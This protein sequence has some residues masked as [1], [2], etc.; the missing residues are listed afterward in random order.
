MKFSILATYYQKVNSPEVVQRFIDSLK[1]QTF[2]DFEVLIAH[3]G[4]EEIPEFDT[5]DLRIRYIQTQH[6]GL[7]GHPQR[8]FMMFF[9]RGDYF[10]NTNVDNVYY[11]N[12]LEEIAKVVKEDTLTVFSVKMIGL[13]VVGT[14]RWYDTP[15]KLDRHYVLTGFPVKFGN[16]DLMQLVAHKNIWLKNGFWNNFERDSDG[17][18]YE[19]LA[20]KYPVRYMYNVL[21]EHY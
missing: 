5:G 1:A 19:K 4:L 13:N 15:R 14:K 20:E 9:A 18:M 2:K 3:D 12:A 11:H 6:Y 16:I 7:W 10:L 21:A 17:K 8:T